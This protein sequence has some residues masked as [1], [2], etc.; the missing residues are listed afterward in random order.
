MPSCS[1]CC[2]VRPQARWSDRH[3]ARCRRQGFREPSCQQDA[4]DHLLGRLT[5]RRALHAPFLILKPDFQSLAGQG[6]DKYWLMIMVSSRDLP[7]T[8]AYPA[9]FSAAATAGL[10]RHGGW[11]GQPA[12]PWF[13]IREGGTGPSIAALLL[14]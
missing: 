13:E 7:A 3:S 4:R 6:S 5:S 8:R 11:D 12:L 14:V 10:R 9:F 1:Q 2:S